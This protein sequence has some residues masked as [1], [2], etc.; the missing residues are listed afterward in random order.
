MKNKKQIHPL[1]IEAL[2]TRSIY[3]LAKDLYIAY[4]TAFAWAH[5]MRQPSRLALQ[6]L[7]GLPF[8][9]PAA[10]ENKKS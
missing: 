1:V 10:H 6:Q 2:K 7:Q 3:R 5:G 4:S 9:T 8:G